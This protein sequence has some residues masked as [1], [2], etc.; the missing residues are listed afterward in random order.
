MRL[1]SVIVAT[2]ALVFGSNSALAVEFSQSV[3]PI[4]ADHCFTCHGP[5]EETREAELRLDTEEGIL[6]A[7]GEGEFDQSEAWR[8][9]HSEDPDEQMPPPGFP[10]PLTDR[11]RATIKQWMEEGARWSQHWA[12]TTPTRP[13]PPVHESAAHP[14]DRFALAKL[15]DLGLTQSATAS[16]ETLIRRLKFD[17]LGLP[18]TLEEISTFVEDQSPHAYELLV[19]RLLASPHFGERMASEWLDGA[20]Y[21]DTNGYQNDFKRS[22]WP[23]RDWVINAFNNNQP[24]DE[25]VVEQLAGDMLPN[26][27]QAQ[28]IA[29]GFNRNNRTVT[30]GGSIEAEWLVE[31]VVDRVET[32]AT[33]FLGLTMGC[34]RCHD[35]KYDPISQREFYQF[36]SFFHNVNEK[37]FYQEARG[38]VAPVLPVISP[39]QQRNLDQVDLRLAEAESTLKD[40]QP[41]LEMLT[42]QWKLSALKNSQQPAIPQSQFQVYF[43]GDT[44]AYTALGKKVLPGTETGTIA[45]IEGVLGTVAKFT[46][47]HTLNYDQTIAPDHDSPFAFTFWVKPEKLGAIVDKI[48]PNN[49]SRGWDIYWKNPG[50]LEMHLIHSWPEDA[51]KISTDSENAVPQDRWSHV[52]ISYDGSGKAAGITVLVN[53]T[54][55]PLKVEA[56]SLRSSFSVDK[57]LQFGR[58]SRGFTFFGSVTDFRYF[59]QWLDQA[60]VKAIASEGLARLFSSKEQTQ[61]GEL[62]PQ[63]V[64]LFSAF[65]DSKIARQYREAKATVR[66]TKQEIAKLEKS[67]PTVMV[68]E[69]LPTPRETFVLK[70]GEYDKPDLTQPVTA[71]IPNFLGELPEGVKKDRLALA[72][73][74]VSG[75]NPLTA[76]VRV[77]RIWQ[78]LFGI[79]L[80]KTTENFGVQA[81]APS[82]PELLDWLATEFVRLGWDSKKLLKLIVT[83]DTYQQSSA[84][85]PQQLAADPAN[86]YFSRGP[87]FRLPAEMI[88]DNALAVSGLLTTSIGGDAFKPYQPEG[89]WDELAGGAGEGEYV[90]SHGEELYR[91]SLY[92]YRKRTVPH[93]VTNTFDAPA[94][95]IC[96][97]YRA[98]TNTPLQAL[99]LLNDVTYVEAARKLG[100]RMLVQGGAYDHERLAFGFQ[101]VT[102]RKPTDE[103][104]RTLVQGLERHKHRFAE[105]PAAAAMFLGH[106]ESNSQVDANDEAFAAY[107]AMGSVLLNLDE[108]ITKE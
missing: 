86:R 42:Q 81:D 50:K 80:V 56:D 60:R 85:S 67:Y 62:S 12:F 10:K 74:I 1:S 25:F 53:G 7:F 88:R 63:R 57:P 59:D 78:M 39:E 31:N 54:P 83:S 22:M 64:H 76:R 91:R 33:V 15:Q 108:A 40:L 43:A 29:T 19:D 65:S 90:Q 103:E 107:A 34:A 89:L 46:G 16:R 51:L 14:I 17:L 95:E 26:P 73:W 21:A 27:T 66:S 20:R 18:P 49:L 35:H 41:Q 45:W 82:H 4:L 5:D 70:R 44:K 2:V 38:N 106:G 97:V 104:L 92:I 13:E 58:T 77:N 48:D 72:R 9:I 105:N 79:G 98:R 36:F 71:D 8:R 23:W 28:R 84:I 99:A 30:E 55:V 24:F 6:H 94:Y 11:Q 37:G 68:M 52:A 96:Q 47:L 93:P 87:R 61:G 69:E 102:A 75:E 100:E 32:T 3:R 101:L